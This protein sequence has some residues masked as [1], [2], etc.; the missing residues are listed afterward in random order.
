MFIRS[1]VVCADPRLR[2]HVAEGHRAGAQVLED[3]D[4]AD[5][6]VTAARRVA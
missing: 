3:G 6:V 1:G 4:L 2:R 5:I